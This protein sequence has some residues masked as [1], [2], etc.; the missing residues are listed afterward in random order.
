MTWCDGLARAARRRWKGAALSL[1][2]GSLFVLASAAALTYAAFSLTSTDPNPTQQY[3][4]LFG[5]A[6]EIAYGAFFWI[7][8]AIPVAV[9]V[10]LRTLRRN[11]TSSVSE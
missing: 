6:I 8:L 2:L 9:V 3:R 5:A 11:G 1:G 4:S 7:V 10:F